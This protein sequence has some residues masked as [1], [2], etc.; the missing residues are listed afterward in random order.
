M[1]MP[2]ISRI[3]FTVS[4]IGLFVGSHIA[5]YLAPTHIFNDRWPPHA[6]FHTGQTLSMSFFLAV[7]T[8]FFAWRKSSDLRSSI[9]ATAGFAA[10]YWITQGTAI[11]YPGTAFI[12]PEFMTP[13]SFHFGLPPQAFVE[14]IFLSVIAIASWLALRKLKKA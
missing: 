2:M 8:I 9:Y 13:T 3:L 12:D 10:V 6:K 1:K 5:D 14:I 4:A 11:I 7:L